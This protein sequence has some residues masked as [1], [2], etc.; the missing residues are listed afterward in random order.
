MSQHKRKASSHN[1]GLSP[2]KRQKPCSPEWVGIEGILNGNIETV[3]H[4]VTRLH[5]KIAP[6]D[7][8]IWVSQAKTRVLSK[9]QQY[10]DLPTIKATG[11][12]SIFSGC[13]RPPSVDK[14]RWVREIGPGLVNALLKYKAEDRFELGELNA[15]LCMILSSQR[16][17]I[18]FERSFA[19]VLGHHLHNAFD[20]SII[21]NICHC[22]VRF[23]FLGGNRPAENADVSAIWYLMVI[24]VE[25]N[26]LYFIDPSPSCRELYKQQRD[27]FLHIRGLWKQSIY[28]IDPDISPPRKA[29]NLPLA[30]LNSEVSSGFACIINAYLLTRQPRELWNSIKG[31]GTGF[32]ASKS[33]IKALMKSFEDCIGLSVHPQWQQ[34]PPITRNKR[35]PQVRL[36][37]ISFDEALVAL[38]LSVK[39]GNWDDL[40]KLAQSVLGRPP[41]SSDEFSISSQPGP[42]TIISA[43]ADRYIPWTPRAGALLLGKIPPDRSDQKLWGN[44]IGPRIANVLLCMAKRGRLDGFE[45]TAYLHMVLVDFF[46]GGYRDPKVVIENCFGDFLM[47]GVPRDVEWDNLVMENKPRFLIFRRGQGIVGHHWYVIIV[48][49]D[50]RLAYCFDSMAAQDTR[51]EHIEAFA[52]LQK[53]WAVRIPKIPAPEQMLELASF[54]QKDYLTSGFLCLYHI[55]LLFRAPGR[56]GRLKHGDVIATQKYLDRVIKLAENYIGVKVR[57]STEIA[58]ISGPSPN[59]NDHYS[60]IPKEETIS[61]RSQERRSSIFESLPS[62]NL[63][64]SR[65]GFGL[66]GGSRLAPTP[67]VPHSTKQNRPKAVPVQYTDIIDLT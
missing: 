67:V 5:G 31:G 61:D 54:K 8:Q 20:S 41:T 43:K 26:I 44:V 22:K 59:A 50:A 46:V 33:F 25:E 2:R 52:L 62:R 48:D 42:P 18:G 40:N 51:A 55:A 39:R 4:L 9:R 36:P 30:Q 64:D 14:E 66:L 32:E 58:P 29:I 1:N 35:Y 11:P 49:T 38:A 63:N 16:P 37:H 34:P 6:D 56:L 12:P 10:Y 53:E 3:K 24:D 45:I 28:P 27:I 19:K 21:R 57:A 65:P 13:P 60:N 15:M 23:L 47:K 7:V 17:N